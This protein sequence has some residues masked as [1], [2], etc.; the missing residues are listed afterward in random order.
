MVKAAK[1][2]GQI[3]IMY[4]FAQ[5]IPFRVYVYERQNVLNAELACAGKLGSAEGGGCTDHSFYSPPVGT[6]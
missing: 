6:V 5:Y 4:W 3:T 2:T 1:S